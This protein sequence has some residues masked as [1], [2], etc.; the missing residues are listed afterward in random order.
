MSQNASI[1]ASAQGPVECFPCSLCKVDPI[2][3]PRQPEMDITGLKPLPL[4]CQAATQCHHSSC[5]AKC[6]TEPLPWKNHPVSYYFEKKCGQQPVLSSN[7]NMHKKVDTVGAVSL[8]EPSKL[9]DSNSLAIECY[10][11]FF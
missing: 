9:C 4:P 1:K 10:A 3:S 5:P 11:K 7:P 8:A 6:N 2:L